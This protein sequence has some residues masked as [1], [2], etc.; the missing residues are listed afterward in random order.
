VIWILI[1]AGVVVVLVV[2]GFLEWRSWKT[3][4]RDSLLT[5]HDDLQGKWTGLSGGH[6][7]DDSPRP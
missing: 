2:L 4:G 7:A 3:P 5:A 1:G 6:D